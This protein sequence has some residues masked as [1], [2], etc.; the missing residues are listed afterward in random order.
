[1]R[2]EPVTRHYTLVGT[3]FDYL[4]RFFLEHASTNCVTKPWVAEGSVARLG[5]VARHSGYTQA[6][7][8]GAYDRMKSMLREAKE[9]HARYMGTGNLD[10]GLIKSCI[11]LAQMDVFYRS[12]V[13]DP[14]LGRADSGDVR[15][16]RNLI[17]VVKPETFLADV[18]CYLNPHFGYGSEL[19]SG[20]DADLIVDGTLIDVKTT[21]SLSF[22]QAHYN[23]LAGYYILS[24]IGQI[25]GTDDVK[26]SRV[27]IYFSRYGM[28]HTVPVRDI[29][30]RPDFDGFVK[31]FERM[32]R[33]TFGRD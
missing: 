26:I 11:F 15:D 27:G 28:L 21:K 31:R 5:S 7:L 17:S 16:L 24:R 33:E 25:N 10:D 3:A 19:V 4:L 20:A 13:I 14:N 8:A 32:A 22:T 9:T 2:A 6:Q 18:T 1:M 12:G 23:Q 29:E 30:D